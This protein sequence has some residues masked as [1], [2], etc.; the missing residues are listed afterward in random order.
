MVIEAEDERVVDALVMAG[1][2]LVDYS[3]YQNLA[4][5]IEAAEHNGATDEAMRLNGLGERILK[6]TEGAP[7]DAAR[8]IQQ[9]SQILGEI[10]G[11]DDLDEALAERR[12][13]SIRSCPSWP[14]TCRKPIAAV[15]RELSSG[16]RR[17]GT[18]LWT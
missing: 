17:S 2:P 12:P 16:C 13:T 14:P 9:Y 11:A 18:R 1:R 8:A 6:F 5:R 15:K 4:Q 3:F 7:T 10:L